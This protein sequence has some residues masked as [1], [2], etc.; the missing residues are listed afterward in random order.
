MP[1]EQ[2]RA[3]STAPTQ[4][5]SLDSSAEQLQAELRS[6]IEREE[7]TRAQTLPTPPITP[8]QPSAPTG[9]AQ[10]PTSLLPRTNAPSSQSRWQDALRSP[11]ADARIRKRRSARRE[12]PRRPSSSRR[13]SRAVDIYDQLVNSGSR[14]N[15]SRP[16][17]SNRRRRSAEG[18]DSEERPRRRRRID[19]EPQAGTGE[20]PRSLRTP[21]APS[22]K[23]KKP[24]AV[25]TGRRSKPS[26]PLPG[27]SP[28]EEE[29]IEEEPIEEETETTPK[30]KPNK[31]SRTKSLAGQK[32]RRV[33][34]SD[35][36]P[37]PPAQRRKLSSK[38]P[39]KLGSLGRELDE[40]IP[41]LYTGTSLP[42]PK[43]AKRGS[44]GRERQ[45]GTEDAR[46]I[47]R[48]PE[49][50]DEF[51]EAGREW[52]RS[53]SLIRELRE[54]EESRAIYLEEQNRAA[55]DRRFNETR[56]SNAVPPSEGSSDDN[57]ASIGAE[58]SAPIEEIEQRAT[59]E[60]STSRPDGME[61]S[62]PI[63]DSIETDDEEE[64]PGLYGR[65]FALDFVRSIWNRTWRL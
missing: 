8:K 47:A 21:V 51:E 23:M 42:Q 35:D 28:I 37:Q 9:Q 50:M 14:R 29:P 61:M 60:P 26:S 6:A 3:G 30:E 46:R 10:S 36:S 64:V 44:T 31:K 54:D 2:S 11:I 22:R 25:K 7:R 32:R 63:R 15:S 19:A 5:S 1:S 55:R 58:G 33:S 17:A 65:P 13:Y 4:T 18:S 12:A 39:P 40:M 20:R 53:E 49:M 41:E 27:V 24:W 38:S 34:D 62:P 16:R 45:R 48:D 59:R 52:L 43:R 57:R 56:E